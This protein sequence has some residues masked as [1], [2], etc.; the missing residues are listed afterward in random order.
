MLNVDTKL[1]SKVIAT[2]LKKNLNNL[3]NE[4][5]ITYLNNRFISEGGR[6]ISPIVEITDLL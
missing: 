6:L 2:G 4:Y 5:Q 1:I 3:I